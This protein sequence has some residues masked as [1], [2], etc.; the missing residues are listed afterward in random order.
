MARGRIYSRY[1][2]IVTALG[3]KE[4]DVYRVKGKDGRIVDVLRI[5]DPGTGKVVL[6]DLEAPRESLSLEEFLAR[7]VKKLEDAG[8]PVSERILERVKS[9]LLSASTKS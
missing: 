5:M 2:M 4:L 6:V 3:L 1:R 9:K 8:M 7:L